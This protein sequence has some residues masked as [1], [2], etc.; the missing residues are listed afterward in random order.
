MDPKNLV[1]D[2]ISEDC[3]AHDAKQHSLERNR[4]LTEDDNAAK[5][6][7][8]GNCDNLHALHAEDT[9]AQR[10]CHIWLPSRC[11]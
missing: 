1:D 9:H 11:G 8:S 4:T 10:Q 3:V 7:D 2:P 6:H 5:C